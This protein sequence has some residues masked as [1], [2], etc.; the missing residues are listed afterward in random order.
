LS[1][2]TN[3]V[4]AYLDE[5]SYKRFVRAHGKREKLREETS[6]KE[7]SKSEYATFLIREGLEIEEQRLKENSPK[8]GRAK[9]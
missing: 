2:R 6:T 1:P 8:Q 7:L 4:T 9:T 3:S 5:K